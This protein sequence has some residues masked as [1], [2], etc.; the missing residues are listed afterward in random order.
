VIHGGVNALR[1]TP[2]FDMT[3]E[4]I[5]VVVDIVAESVT[6]YE[7]GRCGLA[8]SNPVLKAPQESALETEIS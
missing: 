5:T 2:W 4:E 8:A 6:A 1:F 3:P 7:V